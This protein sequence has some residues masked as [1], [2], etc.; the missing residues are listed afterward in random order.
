MSRYR[1]IS[2]RCLRAVF[3]L[4]CTF[5]SRLHCTVPTLLYSSQNP[6]TLLGPQAIFQGRFS[7]MCEFKF[8]ETE[9]VAVDKR[10]DEHQKST[11]DENTVCYIIFE[12][13]SG[14]KRFNYTMHRTPSKM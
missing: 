14:R 7:N 6:T 4:F 2:T 9:T 1:G 12:V 3:S 5:K 11:E 10:R 8:R 13:S